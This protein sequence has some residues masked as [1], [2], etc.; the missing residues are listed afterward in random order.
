MWLYFSFFVVLVGSARCWLWSLVFLL[1][2]FL[3][4]CSSI[5]SHRC[6][7]PF[8]IVHRWPSIS[9]KVNSTETTLSAIWR[10]IT[11]FIIYFSLSRITVLMG[12]VTVLRTLCMDILFFF[13][14][15]VLGIGER[16]LGSSVFQKWSRNKTKVGI[17]F[18][19]NIEFLLNLNTRFFR[20]GIF[21]N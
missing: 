12:S 1:T 17:K 15:G 14:K 2:S 13:V 6:S 3:A 18:G 4:I 16:V 8:Y 9:S 19:I 11:L 21:T 20:K 5:R 10:L 7:S